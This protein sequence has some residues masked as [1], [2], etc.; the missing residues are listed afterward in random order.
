MSLCQ[1]TIEPDAVFKRH[2]ADKFQMPDEA[3]AADMYEL[4]QKH[5]PP[6]TFRPPDFQITRE[7]HACLHNAVAGVAAI[8]R[9]RARRTGA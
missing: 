7:G 1:L 4:T 9:H 5:A 3:L 2:A 8:L 6:P